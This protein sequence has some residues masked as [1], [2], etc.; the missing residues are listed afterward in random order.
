MARE[1][2]SYTHFS[3]GGRARERV[4]ERSGGDALWPALDSFLQREVR[5]RYDVARLFV[6][7]RTE[8]GDGGLIDM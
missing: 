7:K 1:R 3:V 5:R 4:A 6:T 8:V 2:G